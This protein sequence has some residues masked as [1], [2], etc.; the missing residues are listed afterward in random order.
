MKS[1]I[2]I[3]IIVSWV[4]LA[5]V[6]WAIP[7]KSVHSEWELIAEKD[8]FTAGETQ[9]IGIRVVLDKHWHLYWENAGDSGYTVTVEW[10]LPEGFEAGPVQYP[11][12]GWLEMYG[13][14]SYVYEGEAVFLVDITAPENL[15]AGQQIE[16]GA[17]VDF[18]VCEEA[19]IPGDAKLLLKTQAIEQSQ[20]SEFYDSI[21]EAKTLL[22]IQSTDWKTAVVDNGQSFALTVVAPAGSSFN[23]EAFTYF[24]ADGWVA[25][26]GARSVAAEGRVYTQLLPK[27][28]L[29]PVKN[30]DRFRGVLVSESKKLFYALEVDVPFSSNEEVA[31]LVEQLGVQNSGTSG[32]SGF[33]A[34][35]NLTLLGATLLAFVGG[36]ILNLMPCVFPVVSIK[37]LGFVQQAGEDRKK[38]RNHG[39]VF[40]SGVVL[41]FWVFAILV[42]VTRGLG[43][44]LS[45]GGLFQIPIVVAF[46][47]TVMFALGLN[48]SGVFEIGESLVG[49]GSGLQRKSGYSG[50]FFSGVLATLVATPCTAPFM[51]P[52]LTFAYASPS[53]YTLIVFSAL[54]AGLAAPYLFLSYFP[55]Y[56]KILP[57]PGAWM[58]TFK[59]SLAFLLYLAVVWLAWVFGS[60]V[61]VTGMAGLL[62]SLVVVGLGAWIWGKWGS[63][64]KPKN[65]RLIA[66][67][68]VAIILGTGG[69]LQYVSS[70]QLPPLL[71]ESS[72]SQINDGSTIAWQKWSPEKVEQ[73]VAEGKTVYVDFTATWC[74]TCQVNKKVAFTDKDVIAYFHDN[75]IVPLKGDW[76]RRDPIIKGEL[77]KFGR[78]GVPTNIIYRPSGANTLLP[79]VLTPGVVLSAFE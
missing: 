72:D 37:I 19:C 62:L 44:A 27:S 43:D 51:A 76:T 59:K 70:N 20:N 39:L 68:V 67:V 50:S 32:G 2:L 75:G 38:I 33:A 55:A 74:L 69:F 17:Y 53:V 46:V 45:W 7:V 61:G 65:T 18:L 56:L 35:N 12:P 60:L 11:A 64:A 52:A 66:G 47:A 78:T 1:K 73:L 49:V 22:P 40:A 71:A 48:M 25:T 26:T 79:E 3:S 34:N 15:Q 8:G 23:G 57:K 13:L 58:E 5:S 14:V 54:G 28:E 21:A 9:T 4:F 42:I 77:Q 30:A 41:F 29:Q 31:A 24:S 10:T 36:L 6:A 63:L 16:L